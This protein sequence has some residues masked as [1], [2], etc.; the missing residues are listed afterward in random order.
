VRVADPYIYAP[1]L[2]EVTIRR[3]RDECLSLHARSAGSAELPG[4]KTED[5]S[6]SWLSRTLA[7]PTITSPLSG[8]LAASH[9]MWFVFPQ[10]AGLGYSRA[11]RTCAI[12]SLDEARA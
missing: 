1:A 6:G 12:T 4:M 10:I 9:W 5:C 3:C 8:V 11:S 7:A 2:A